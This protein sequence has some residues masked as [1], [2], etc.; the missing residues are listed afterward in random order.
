MKKMSAN[1]FENS[2][3]M[4]NQL[5]TLP[6]KKLVSIYSDISDYR[7]FINYLIDLINDELPFLYLDKEFKYKIENVI[8]LHRFDVSKEE[9]E[10]INQIICVLN[11]INDDFNLSLKEQEKV[12]KDYLEYQQ[13]IRKLVFH[14]YDQLASSL[15][16]DAIVMA[17]LK[18]DLSFIKEDP[19]FLASMNY[20]LEVAPDGF[21]DEIMLKNATIKTSE[22]KE[23]YSYLN[24]GIKA[25]SIKI[26]NKI[27][28]MQ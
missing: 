7:I 6:S 9:K 14:S 10:S 25:N 4:K 8:E 3:I 27:K 22:I 1:E 19:Y 12:K 18:N 2:L 17:A 16:Y 20:L 5:V 11:T 24:L 26:L 28:Q 15:G 21:F 23:S 13:S